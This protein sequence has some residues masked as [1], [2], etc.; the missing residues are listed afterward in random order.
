MAN[1]VSADDTQK[2][3]GIGAPVNGDV[4]DRIAKHYLL[5]ANDKSK[6]R[7]YYEPNG[8]TPAFVDNGL[9]LTTTSDSPQVLRDMIAV[10]QHRG[11][12][13][14]TVIGTSAFKQAA[15]QEAQRQGLT[16]KGF[17]PSPLDV[18]RVDRLCQDGDARA[19]LVKSGA[20]RK[21]RRG[22]VGAG[23]PSN[24][25]SVAEI[26]PEI[27]ALNDRTRALAKKWRDAP[28]EVRAADPELKNAQSRYVT[29]LAGINRFAK[30]QPHLFNEDNAT[31]KSTLI[32]RARETIGNEIARGRVFEPQTVIAPK[33]INEPRIA[34]PKNAPRLG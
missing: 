33:L 24:A 29:V 9:A 11:W 26:S 18:A 7:E 28:A 12:Q 3:E 17:K 10:A 31:L 4:P 30:E 1:S 15:W 32:D 22:K 25:E 2:I 27:V 13:T 20:E 19:S 23:E 8:K 5:V 14:I 6:V 21:S 16:V 34:Q